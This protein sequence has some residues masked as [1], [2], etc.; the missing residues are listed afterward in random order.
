MI[1]PVDC[2]LWI[3]AI[4]VAFSVIFVKEVFGGTGMNIFN[5][6]L[7]ARIFMFLDT[8]PKCQVMQCGYQVILCLE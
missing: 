5:V 1:I 3:L 8:L 6:A 4:A 2:P 7:A